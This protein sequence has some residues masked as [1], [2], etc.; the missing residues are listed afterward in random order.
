[1]PT[2]RP[3]LIAAPESGG[4]ERSKKRCRE[5]VESSQYDGRRLFFAGAIEGLGNLKIAAALSISPRS[6]GS[7]V[8]NLL[9]KLDVES[10]TGAAIIAVRRGIS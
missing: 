2:S 3:V 7:R 8:T 9:A 6:V 10:C 5:A 4:R 1:M